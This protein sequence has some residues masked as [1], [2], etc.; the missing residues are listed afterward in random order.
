[1]TAKDH[2]R[3]ARPIAAATVTVHN[4]EIVVVVPDVLGKNESHQNGGGRRFTSEATT[5]FRASMLAGAGEVLISK[6]DSTGHLAGIGAWRAEV[7]GVWPKKRK[8]IEG[9]NIDFEAPTGDAD[10]PVSQSFDALKHAGVIDD[11]A[12]IVAL[13]AFNLY[14]RGVRST[15]IRLVP[16]RDLAERDAAIAHLLPLVPP[17][18][19]PPAKP[20]R[21]RRKVKAAEQLPR[22]P[23]CGES[24]SSQ[25]GDPRGFGCQEEVS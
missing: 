7:L 25:T 6:W 18:V 5:K 13:S 19:E 16:V 20:A 24:H 8:K 4:N 10:A 14:R 3:V 12:R 15:I 22:C 21:S 9:R 11:D 17:A 23:E 2:K 1:M